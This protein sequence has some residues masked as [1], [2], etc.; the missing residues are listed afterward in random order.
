[1][2][3]TATLALLGSV[4]TVDTNRGCS[5]TACAALPCAPRAAGL[6]STGV[7]QSDSSL[8]AGFFSWDACSTF[9]TGG[10]GGAGRSSELRGHKNQTPASSATTPAAAHGAQR[11]RDSA[12][13]AS[14]TACAPLGSP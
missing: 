9:C 11:L 8:L 3:S 6:S 13:G 5:A 12:A 1:M 7:S 4:S 14:E 2:P 10:R